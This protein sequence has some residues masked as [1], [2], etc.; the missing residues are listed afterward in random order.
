MNNIPRI[1]NYGQIPP[2]GGSPAGRDGGGL[3]SAGKTSKSP[4]GADKVEISFQAQ[5]MGKIAM[6]P[7]VR[8]EKVDEVRQSLAMGTYDIEGKLS[9]AVE[10]F[11]DDYV[12]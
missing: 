6:M 2:M 10:R 1:N 9:T 12:W 5:L 4:P 3:G 8:S 7:E 11:I